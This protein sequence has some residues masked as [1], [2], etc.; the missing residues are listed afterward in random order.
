MNLHKIFSNLTF[1]KKTTNQL[2]VDIINF[3]YFFISILF[4]IVVFVIFTFFSGK[5]QNDISLSHTSSGNI[6]ENDTSL[7]V[8]NFLLKKLRS[9]YNNFNYRI[10]NNDSII[11]V[12]KE[13]GIVD[14]EINLIIKKLKEK[15]LTKIY[16]YR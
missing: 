13:F 4:L 7:N 3:K 12:L 10:K 8:Q 15:K 9:P 16:V 14:D 5:H 1:Y 11:N 6:Q 2:K